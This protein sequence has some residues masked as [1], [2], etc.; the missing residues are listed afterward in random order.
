MKEL[1]Q[2][3]LAR[4]RY[5]E[6]TIELWKL[7]RLV[8]DLRFEFAFAYGVFGFGYCNLFRFNTLRKPT[9]LVWFS[10]LTFS[11]GPMDLHQGWK[12]LDFLEKKVFF[13]F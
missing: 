2:L 3:D 1:S 6:R 9:D 13:V 4:T 5:A 12:K 7:D 8:A 10:F 11:Y